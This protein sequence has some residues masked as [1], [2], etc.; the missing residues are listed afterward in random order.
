[1]T[2]AIRQLLDKSLSLMII[3]CMASLVL[4]VLWQVFSRFIL[5]NP[6][7]ATDEIACFL[8]VCIA[9]LGGAYTAGQHRHLV[10]DIL[11]E[12]LPRSFR[13]AVDIFCQL[14]IAAFALTVM[15]AGGGWFAASALNM[16]QISPATGVYVGCLYCV[17]PLS[18]LFLLLYSLLTCCDL[19]FSQTGEKN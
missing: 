14:M 11:I 2:T 13:L 4:I 3:A 12:K 17:I 5:S 9:L 18:G 16:G 8:M 10:I 1:M 6:S 7:T 15:I 19:I